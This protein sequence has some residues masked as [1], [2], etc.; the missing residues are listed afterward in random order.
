MVVDWDFIGTNSKSLNKCFC[1][2]SF[3]GQSLEYPIILLVQFR[4]FFANL[5]NVAVAVE[6]MSMTTG[7]INGVIKGGVFIWH[8]KRVHRLM[9][10]LQSN[11]DS[12]MTI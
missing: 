1:A 5:S 11:V 12:S 8:R 2:N 7:A 6:N 10:E 3:V 9:V 4:F